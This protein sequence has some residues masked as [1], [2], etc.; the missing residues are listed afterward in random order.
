MELDL[1]EMFVGGFAIGVAVEIAIRTTLMYLYTLTVVRLLGK[2][3]MGHLSP[4]ELVIIVSLGSAVGDP[5][6]YADI[7]LVHG[8]IVIAVIV[9][10]QRLLQRATERAPRLE[11]VFEGKPR[12]LVSGGVI[13]EEA[14]AKEDL[15]EAELFTALRENSVEHLGQVRL[16]YLEPSGVVSVF[17]VEPPVAPGKSTLPD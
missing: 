3:G 1:A 15:S 13:D 16:A 2:R 6:L 10:L 7:P 17:K 8:M 9:V 12:R 4:F 5:M 14:L 11:T